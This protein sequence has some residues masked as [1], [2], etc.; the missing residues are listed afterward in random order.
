MAGLNIQSPEKTDTGTGYA[1]YASAI[2]TATTVL[3]GFADTA[4]FKS[5]LAAKRS[6]D[7]FNAK[8]LTNSYELNYVKSIEAIDSINSA[9]GDKLSERGLQAMKEASLARVAAAETGTTGGTTDISIQEAF[10]NENFD[11]A[12]I[13]TASEQQVKNAFIGLEL[14]EN[15]TRNQLDSMLLGGGVNISTDSALAGILGGLSTGTQTFGLLP[16]EDKTEFF[17]IS[18]QETR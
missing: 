13:V 14:Q 11:A 8:N 12:N 1:G 18:P 6:S 5:Q 7:I 2:S 10:L 15:Q 4:A 17:G 16:Q 3:S 9:L